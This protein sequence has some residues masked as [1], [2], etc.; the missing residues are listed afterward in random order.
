MRERRGLW[1]VQ[2]E[3]LVDVAVDLGKCVTL[4]G[5]GR[6]KLTAAEEAA[7]RKYADWA[8]EALR[9]SSRDERRSNASH[10]SRALAI[11]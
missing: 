9:I 7:R 10:R 6:E 1:T 8:M 3:P 11:A 2:A 5:N 4:V